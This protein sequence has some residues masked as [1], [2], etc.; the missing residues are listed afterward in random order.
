MQRRGQDW[1]CGVCG[2]RRERCA[3]CG[4][5]RPVTFARPG[6]AAAM[7][8]SARPVT[9]GTRPQSSSRS[10][11]RDRPRAAGGDRGR[12]GDGSSCPGRAAPP[13]RLG[14]ARP[15]RAAHRRGRRR[16][17]AVGAAA[18]RQICATPGAS[19]IV[20]PPCPRCGRVIHLHRRIDG[21]WCCRNC[22]ARSRFQPCARCG[23]VQQ[24]AIRDEH[25]RPLCPHCLV[26][27]PANQEICTGCGRRRPVSVRSPDGPLCPACRAGDDDDLLDLRPGRTRATCPRRP[28]SRGAKPAS[29]AGPAAR[30]CGQHRQGPRRHQDRA[31]L[32][33]L[34]PPRTPGSGAAAPAAGRPAGSTPAGAPAAPARQRLREL[35]GS[36]T[37]DI[38]PGLQA[39]YHALATAERPATVEAW[40]NRSAAPAILRDAG[41]EGAHPPRPRRAPR[42]QAGRAP[43]QRPG[44]HRDPA[45]HAMSR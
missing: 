3:A 43:A 11:R 37:G 42:G 17:R 34:H 21:Q 19:G 27:D 41:R 45:R 9:A 7:R 20:R 6:R 44:R 40:L 33:G 13:A 23:A 36:E 28:A 12:R 26:T 31:A 24:V 25:G 1:Y 15:A 10:R 32:R 30:G 5:T 39:L 35:L 8:A 29:S 2:P 38:R 18:D 4:N 16:T 22:V 14:T